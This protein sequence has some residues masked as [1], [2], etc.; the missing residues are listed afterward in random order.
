M[1]LMDRR[2]QY[3]RGKLSSLGPVLGFFFKKKS[4]YDE[5]FK[6]RILLTISQRLMA[7]S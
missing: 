4:D 5:L 7:P 1:T 2:L 3:I 6:S